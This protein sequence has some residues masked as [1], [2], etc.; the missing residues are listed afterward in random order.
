MTIEQ[1]K[2]NNR[3]IKDKQVAMNW[4]Q[5]STLRPTKKPMF[6]KYD[7]CISIYLLYFYVDFNFPNYKVK[8]IKVKIFT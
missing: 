1:N 3:T 7:V 8:D 5:G 6:V 2:I 4:K